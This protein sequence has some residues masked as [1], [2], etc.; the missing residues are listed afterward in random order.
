MISTMLNR[1]ALYIRH[2]VHLI[3]Q[4]RR[5]RCIVKTVDQTLS[6]GSTVELTVEFLANFMPTTIWNQVLIDTPT[7]LELQVIDLRKGTSDF[8]AAI[9][10]AVDDIDDCIVIDKIDFYTSQFVPMESKLD[11]LCNM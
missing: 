8:A 4:K 11:D 3:L 1:W 9:V 5:D 10:Y 7:Y 2:H 6:V